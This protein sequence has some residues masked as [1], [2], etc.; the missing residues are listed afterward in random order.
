MLNVMIYSNQSNHSE[1]NPH[2]FSMQEKNFMKFIKI[3]QIKFGFRNN[4]LKIKKP[5]TCKNDLFLFVLVYLVM[6]FYTIM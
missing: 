5:R 4:I 1:N 6:Y 2:L 3:H